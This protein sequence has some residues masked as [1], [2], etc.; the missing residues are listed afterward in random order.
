MVNGALAAGVPAD[1]AVM[2][3]WLTDDVITGNGSTPTGDIEKVTGRPAT[4]FREFAER[5]VR[6][7]T[8]EAS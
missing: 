4:T 1:Y 8:G 2:L 3:R 6:A 5:N 7:W